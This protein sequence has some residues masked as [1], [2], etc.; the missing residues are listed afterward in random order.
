M[1]TFLFWSSPNFGQKIGRILGVII[2][3]LIFVL[4]KFSEVPGL[5]LFKILRMLL[6]EQVVDRR[7]GGSLTQRPKCPFAISWPGQLGE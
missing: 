6:G 4:L 5:P 7:A 2:Y 1:K 3:I